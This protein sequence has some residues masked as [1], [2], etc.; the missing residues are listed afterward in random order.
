MAL[1]PFIAIHFRYEG[2]PYPVFAFFIFALAFLP[3]LLSL[4]YVPRTSITFSREG[5]IYTGAAM[6][7]PRRYLWS[8]FEKINIVAIPSGIGG[9]PAGWRKISFTH[10]SG[11]T[12]S[13]Q[14]DERGFKIF[15][16]VNHSLSIEN[17][18]R[19]FIGPLETVKRENPAFADMG[20]KAGHVALAALGIAPLLLAA[21]YLP[22]RPYL[23]DNDLE[24]PLIYVT[25]L[26]A[27]VLACWYMRDIPQK[28]DMVIPALLFSGMMALLPATLKSFIPV[29]FGH[30][31][32]VVFTVTEE[33]EKSQRWQAATDAEM[34]FLLN[35]FPKER[36]YPGVGTE[37]AIMVY[38]GPWAFNAI[39]QEEFDTLFRKL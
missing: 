15:T 16:G 12:F 21:V 19:R 14:I 2:K 11:K 4:F 29:L 20:K 8:E 24:M 35:A 17:A 13:F 9:K 37:H 23:L 31:E 27:G 30:G 10:R 33:T 39:R 32:R 7:I 1:M 6:H 26:C 5:L 34:S 22:D 25:G 18:A 3:L 36:I 28:L 38:R